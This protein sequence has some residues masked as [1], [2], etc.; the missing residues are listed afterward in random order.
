MMYRDKIIGMLVGGA[1]GDALGKGVETWDTAKIFKAHPEGINQY[2]PPIGHKWFNEEEHP[3][4]TTTDDTQLTVATM[5]GFILGHDEAMAQKSFDP[6]HDAIAAEHVAALKTSTKGWGKTTKEAVRKLR[7]GTHW[8]ES[9]ITDNPM[10]GTGNGV[11]MKI[12]PFAAYD[13][14]HVFHSPNE[15]IK[16]DRHTEV[17]K[18]SAM[19]HYSQMSALAGIAHYEAVARCLSRTENDFDVVDFTHKINK[20]NPRDPDINKKIRHL[21]QN[22][23]DIS[24]RLNII[25]HF[26]RF[27]PE[28][29]D[30]KL[31]EFFGSGG[32]YVYDSLPFTYAAFLREPF[33]VNTICRIVEAGG[34]TDTNA[35]MAGELI[36]ALLGHQ[37][38]LKPENKWTVDGLVGYQELVELGNEFCDCMRIP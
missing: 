5:K 19:T 6:Y 12:S 35:K 34:D 36:G 4:G 3:P 21:T 11:P 15:Y 32:C 9:G 31:R 18:H 27:I 37:H 38:F 28:M 20:A 8:T 1:V 2:V 13:I 23:D 22:N 33:S 30:D 24:L 26:V 25:M 17:V 14:M 10:R 16:Y 29:S 7:D